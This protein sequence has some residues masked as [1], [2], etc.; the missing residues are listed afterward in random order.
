VF[1]VF[2]ALSMGGKRK[3]NVEEEAEEDSDVDLNDL[4]TSKGRQVHKV[5]LEAINRKEPNNLEWDIRGLPCGKFASSFASWIGCCVRQ[6]VPLYLARF[7]NLYKPREKM[8]ME[9]IQV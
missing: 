3:R 2:V 1:F 4:R 5:S 8:M 9:R 7:D 6:F